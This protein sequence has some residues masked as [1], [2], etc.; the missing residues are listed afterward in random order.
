MLRP[1]LPGREELAAIRFVFAFA[2][3]TQRPPQILKSCVPGAQLAAPLHER[4]CRETLKGICMPSN[5][6]LESIGMIVEIAGVASAVAGLV[7]SLHHWPAAAALI[8]GGVAY[9]IGKKL[10]DM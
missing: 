8:G 1:S 6:H 4:A 2:V 9:I 10:R 3:R 7:L 5:A